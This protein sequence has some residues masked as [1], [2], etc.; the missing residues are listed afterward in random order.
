LGELIK[1]WI[2]QRDIS[3]RLIDA[4]KLGRRKKNHAMNGSSPTIWLQDDRGGEAVATALWTH[5]GVRN[6]AALPVVI[7]LPPEEAEQPMSSKAPSYMPQ[8]EDRRAVIQKQIRERRGQRAFRDALRRRYGDR[9]LVTGCRLL[10]VLEAAHIRP[11]RGENDNH[12]E[13]GLL[14]RADIHTLFD[15]NLLGI[16]PEGLLIKL[17]PALGGDQHYAPLEGKKLECDGDCRP[18]AEAL[19]IRYEEFKG[20]LS[21]PSN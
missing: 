20:W 11:Y 6:L 3:Q 1:I 7:T 18:S 2:D 10:D 17:H 4:G 15:L 12:A 14:L 21:R 9:C 8:E 13:N 16:E 5:P 19:R